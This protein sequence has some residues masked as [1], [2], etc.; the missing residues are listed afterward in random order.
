MS[1]SD[2]DYL[3]YLLGAKSPML[4]ISEQR[5]YAWDYFQLHSTQRIATFNFFVSI[6]TAISA[7]AGIAIQVNVN[8]K[9][10]AIL[11]GFLLCLISF[12]FWK[13]D[14]RN[15]QL[16]KLGEEALKLIEAHLDPSDDEINLFRRDDQRVRQYRLHSSHLFWRNYYSYSQ[17]FNILFLCF[18]ALG[19]IAIIAGLLMLLA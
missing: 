8:L 10:A 13:L 3:Q 11:L 1:N 19:L 9:L 5:K 15:R 12:V 7:A 17:S 18:G 6:A 16:I 2:H 4:N 14:E